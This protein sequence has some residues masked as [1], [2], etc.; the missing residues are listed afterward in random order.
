MTGSSW[1][2]AAGAHPEESTIAWSHE[3]Q[4]GSELM[5]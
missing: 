5:L 1:W 4:N 3:E 2:R